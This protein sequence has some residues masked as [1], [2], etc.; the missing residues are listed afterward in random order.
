MAGDDTWAA[1]DAIAAD[2]AAVDP[3]AAAPIRQVRRG[4]SRRLRDR[5]PG[6]VVAVA[7]ALRDRHRWVAYELVY[8]HPGGLDALDAA[9]VETLG[10]GL[11]S[12]ADVDGF[13]RYISG[14]AWGRGRVGDDLIQ[15]W[16]TSPDRWWRRAALVST[17]PLNLRAAG[18]T[19]DTARTIDICERL[20]ADRDDMV[21]KAL[22]WALRELVE[23]DPAAVRA[24]LD[25]HGP[26]VPAR[27][28]REVTSKLVTG[29]KH[30]R[31]P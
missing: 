26:A 3:P 21:V 23:W 1:A 12:W 2:V 17:V 4:W 16:T 14:P 22:S 5:T 6:D 15:A 18:G 13:G 20:V 29:L 11:G 30:A 9:T 8:A 28:R 25:R 24:F 27:V 31:R 19:G 7:L 10:A